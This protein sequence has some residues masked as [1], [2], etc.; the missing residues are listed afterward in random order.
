MTLL[1]LFILAVIWAAV[2]LPPYLQNRSDSRPADSITS[3]RNQLSVLGYRSTGVA[4]QRP[5]PAHRPVYSAYP[6]GYARPVYRPIQGMTRG[7]VRRRR[8]EVFFTLL[9]G[10]GITLMLALM[11]G[12]MVWALHLTVDVL[13][14][15]YTLLLVNIQQRQ[16]E[17]DTTVRYLPEPRPVRRAEPALAL[18]RSAN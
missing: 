16:V 6:A 14:G 9:T 8:R 4:P 7:E 11:L 2:L 18:R 10:A 17:R 5:A 15:G 12:G 1:V 13:L 3:F